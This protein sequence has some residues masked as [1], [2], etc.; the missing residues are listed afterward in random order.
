MTTASSAPLKYFTKIIPRRAG[1]LPISSPPSLSVSC[2]SFPAAMGAPKLDELVMS[3]H[4]DYRKLQTILEL[5]HF[6]DRYCFHCGKVHSMIETFQRMKIENRDPSTPT[7]E[8]QN[9]NASAASQITTKRCRKGLINS[10]LLD[11]LACGGSQKDGL[12]QCS[13]AEKVINN[14]LLYRDQTI[15]YDQ[16]P[17]F[18]YFKACRTLRICPHMKLE[19]DE[20][21]QQFQRAPPRHL[22]D[23][24][25]NMCRYCHTEY[26]IDIRSHERGVVMYLTRW[27]DFGNPSVEK[28][29]KWW[30]HIVHRGRHHRRKVIFEKGSISGAF[31]GMHYRYFNVFSLVQPWAQ[32]QTSTTQNKEKGDRLIS[33]LVALP[34]W[35]RV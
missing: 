19:T 33:K 9:F 10:S 5:D 25:M 23:I 27:K 1:L 11:I 35:I 14:S 32:G 22:T 6:S 17:K 13:G 30:N 28:Q 8:R 31:E 16:K 2:R 15:I 12:V 24:N 4:K 21:Y 7:C 26:R 34:K 3:E 20:T 18:G 29:P